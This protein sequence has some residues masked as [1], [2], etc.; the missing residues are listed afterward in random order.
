VRV[1]A[2]RCAGDGSR[3]GV[4][5]EA[6]SLSVRDPGLRYRVAL[7]GNGT[8]TCTCPGF[9]YAR[10]KD[11]GCRNIDEVREKYEYSRSL[12]FLLSLTGAR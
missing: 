3:A 4:V 8:W 11:G 6:E 1:C 2:A 12:A 5:F 7:L 10:R 9:A